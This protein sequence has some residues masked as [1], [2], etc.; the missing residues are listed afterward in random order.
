M[1]LPSSMVDLVPCGSL[2][3]MAF[4]VCFRTCDFASGTEQQLTLRELISPGINVIP[5]VTT[6]HVLA[7]RNLR[8]GVSFFAGVKE[9][10]DIKNAGT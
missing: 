10:R 6:P 7:T 8:S 1:S 5:M 3:Q 9:E 4:C 2:L